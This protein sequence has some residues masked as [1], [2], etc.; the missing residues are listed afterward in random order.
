MAGSLATSLPASS[1]RRLTDERK[2][3]KF[4]CCTIDFPTTSLLLAARQ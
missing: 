2:N 3:F 4:L 1:N